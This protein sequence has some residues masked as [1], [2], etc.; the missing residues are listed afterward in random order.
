MEEKARVDFPLRKNL[1]WLRA[2]FYQN[3]TLRVY[4]RRY[5]VI[6][7]FVY[8]EAQLSNQLI[9]AQGQAVV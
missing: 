9:L 6:A 5:R 2:D 8:L 1:I 4:L 3:N 7:L